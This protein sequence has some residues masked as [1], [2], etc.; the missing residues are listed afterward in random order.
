MST[1][2]ADCYCADDFTVVEHA[3]LTCVTRNSWADEGVGWERYGLHLA[4]GTDVKRIGPRKNRKWHVLL[5]GSVHAKLKN[6]QITDDIDLAVLASTH[7]NLLNK[8]RNISK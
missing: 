3:Q 2:V 1:G 7:F 5:R 4:V 8:R 6:E